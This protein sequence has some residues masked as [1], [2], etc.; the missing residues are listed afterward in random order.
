MAPN[1][2]MKSPRMPPCPPTSAVSPPGGL[3]T[4]VPDVGDGG[5]DLLAV[6][7]GD[8]HDDLRGGAVGGVRR[9]RDRGRVDVGDVLEP[10]GVAGDRLLVGGGQPARALEHHGRGQRLLTGEPE[11]LVEHAGGLG[12]LRQ[13]GGVVVLLHLREPAGER[14]QRSADEQPQQ[15]H[16]DGSTQR[17]DRPGPEVRADGR[18]CDIWISLAAAPVLSGRTPWFHILAHAADGAPG[19]WVPGVGS[20]AW[21]S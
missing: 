16:D 21:T 17:L 5:L 7:G 11:E 14:A 3:A 20:G 8:R 6:R 18:A 10:R 9:S 13:E 1:A 12:A 4:H 2:V 19:A 15:D